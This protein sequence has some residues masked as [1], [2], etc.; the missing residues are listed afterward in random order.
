MLTSDMELGVM[1]WSW[2]DCYI[3]KRGNAKV[4]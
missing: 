2:K 3:Y 1:G 4:Q